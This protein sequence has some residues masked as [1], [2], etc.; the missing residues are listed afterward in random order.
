MGRRRTLLVKVEDGTGILTV[1]LFHFRQAQVNQFKTGA[2][3]QPFGTP[4]WLGGSIEIIH[5]EYRLGDKADLVEAALTPVYPTVSGLG[6]STAKSMRAALAALN[7]QPPEDLLHNITNDRITLAEAIAFLHNP[8]PGARL[9]HIHQGVHPAQIRLAREELIAHAHRGVRDKER[10]YHAPAITALNQHLLPAYRFT[11]RSATRVAEEPAA[12]M[13]K[14][15]LL[16]LVQGDVGSGKTL[17]AARAA[18]DTIAAGYQVAFMAPTERWRS[19]TMRILPTGSSRQ[20]YQSRAADEPR[21]SRQVVLDQLADGRAPIV[22]GTHA[23][24][25]MTSTFIDLG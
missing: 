10:R 25:K 22:V 5:P 24:F 15:Q 6:Q 2:H 1:R 11:H 21:E 9:D 19:S 20:V 14:T 13:A 12:D 18:L 3:V 4:R 16:R 8:L 7:R 17:V 23:L